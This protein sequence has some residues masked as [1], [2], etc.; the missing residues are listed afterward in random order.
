M[1]PILDEPEQQHRQDRPAE[2]HDGAID[3]PPAP[4]GDATSGARARGPPRGPETR[5]A[6]PARSAAS[7]RES[8]SPPVAEQRQ[9]PGDP[10]RRPQPA[11]QLELAELRA[12][13]AVPAPSRTA[14]AWASTALTT[15]ITSHDAAIS[16]GNRN[17]Q[18]PSSAAGADRRPRSRRSPASADAQELLDHALAGRPDDRAA[19]GRRAVMPSAASAVSWASTQARRIPFEP[20]GLLRATAAPGGPRS[21]PGSPA[22]ARTSPSPTTPAIRPQIRIARGDRDHRR[23]EPHRRGPANSSG[24]CT[25]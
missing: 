14:S 24:S 20:A 15:T 21:A 5:T 12:R 17:I 19:A 4:A 1:R 2:Q 16:P 8:P 22:P 9:Q 25:K 18:R 6:P 23:G 11:R 10:D 7:A 13:A 3:Q